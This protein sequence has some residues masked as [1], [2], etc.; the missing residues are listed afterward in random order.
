M[1]SNN[2]APLEIHQNSRRLDANSRVLFLNRTNMTKKPDSPVFSYTA[3]IPEGNAAQ[4]A[5]F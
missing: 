1:C 2:T 4:T 3:D 5:I